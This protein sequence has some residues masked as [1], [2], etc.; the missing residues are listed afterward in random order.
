MSFSDFA[1]YKRSYLNSRVTEKIFLIYLIKI[2]A[3][4]VQTLHQLGIF[5]DTVSPP[6]NLCRF[7][8]AFTNITLLCLCGEGSEKFAKDA[9]N[10]S[11][12]FFAGLVAKDPFFH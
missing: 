7:Q 10:G 9:V 8:Q 12:A 3:V 4:S 2:C 6:L 1:A 11:S 5:T